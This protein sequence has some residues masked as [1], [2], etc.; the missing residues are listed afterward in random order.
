MSFIHLKQYRRAVEDCQAGIR[1]NAEFPRIYKRQFKAYL[2]LGETNLA[3]ESLDRAVALDPNDATN[4]KDK[5]LMNT[6]IH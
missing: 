5:D 6:V 4:G 2:A 3:K 1:L